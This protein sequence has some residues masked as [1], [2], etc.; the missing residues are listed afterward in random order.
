LI[1]NGTIQIDGGDLYIGGEFSRADLGNLVRNGGNVNIIGTMRNEGQ[2]LT[3]DAST[4]SWNLEEGGRIFGGTI[5][6]MDGAVLTC[7]R[8]TG[9][10]IGVTL[11]IDL[12]ISDT[13]NTTATTNFEIWSGITINRTLSLT[14]ER[15][16]V[17]V[18]GTST[19][20][21][22]GTV[23]M[24]VN[25]FNQSGISSANGGG[26]PPGVS[27]TLT[28]GPDLSIHA[29]RGRIESYSL[30]LQGTFVADALGD[31]I[32]N[33]D[34]NGT[35]S[36]S[37]TIDVDLVALSLGDGTKNFSFVNTG[38]INLHSGSINLG[39]RF[40]LSSLGTLNRS[41]GAIVIKGTFDNSGTELNLNESTGSWRVYGGKIFGGNIRISGGVQLVL[42]PIASELTNVVVNGD[43]N[44]EAPL[45]STNY[46]KL[47]GITVNGN[48]NHA[49]FETDLHITNGLTLN[50]TAV[51]G[52]NVWWEFYGTDSKLDGT[53]TVL[54]PAVNSSA[55]LLT[56][57]NSSLTIGPG[58]SLRGGSGY[59]G[60][61]GW[62]SGVIGG[63][64]ISIINQGRIIADI[65][66]RSLIISPRGSGSLM[67]FGTISA[68][69]GRISILNGDTL[70]S[71][72]PY[73]AMNVSIDGTAILT[74]T[75]EGQMEFKGNLLTNARSR[76]QFNLQGT[77]EFNGVGTAISPQLLEVSSEDRGAIT[78]GFSDNFAI[79]TLKVRGNTNGT[80]AYL[81]LV[82]LSDNSTGGTTEAL[83][84]NTLIVPA[85]ATLDLNGHRVYAKAAL[86]DGNVVNG[87][88]EVIPDSGPIEYAHPTPGKIGTPGELDEWTLY[89]RAGKSVTIEL[90]PGTAG[91]N[92]AITPV[93]QW[94]T[95]QLLN[96]S[97]QIVATSSNSTSGTVIRLTGVQ[98]PTDGTYRLRV[99]ASSGH[100]ASTGNYTISLFDATSTLRSLNLSQVV[101]GNITSP[102]AED[103]WTFT[104]DD[105]TSLR[106]DFRNSSVSGFSFR[107]L[108]PNNSVPI[109]ETSEDSPI[110]TLP[111]PGTY[112]LI[113]QHLTGGTGSY[114]FRLEQTSQRLLPFNGSIEETFTKS[115]Q[116]KLFKVT[117]PT[118]Q[119]LTLQLS[120]P[121]ASDRFEMYASLGSPPS[122]EKYDFR[123][124]A[125]GSSQKITVPNAS[126]GDWYV[127]VYADNLPE[128]RTLSLSASG[129]FTDLTSVV[130]MLSGNSSPV[131]M[132]LTG[133]GFVSGTTV[134][135]VSLDGGTAYSPQIY[136]IDSLTQISAT[137]PASIPSGHYSVRVTTPKGSRE[138]Y[139]SF[140]SISGSGAK[141]ETHLVLPP[142]LGRHAYA[143]LYIEY[144]N[145]GDVP[146][147]APLLSL[148]GSDPSDRPIF[149]LDESRIT[150]KFWSSAL[151]PGAT[152]SL[153][154]V[155]S[156]QQAGIL[157]PGERVRIPVYY[158]GLQQPWDFGDSR[159]ELELRYWT[160][161]DTAPIDW[162][163]KSDSMR[164]S[165]INAEAWSAIFDNLTSEISTTGE[166]V[167]MLN[168]NSIY[169]SRMGKN[170]RD[171]SEL[172]NFEVQQAYGFSVMPTLVSDVDL[173]MPVPGLSLSFSRTYRDA[174]Y[175]RFEYGPFGRG[176]GTEW[177]TVLVAL[178]DR[179]LV[180][181]H[182]PGGSVR[183]YLRDSRNGAYFSLLGD[184][185]TLVYREGGIF[186][187]LSTSGIKTRFL[188]DGRISYVADTND[189]KVTAGYESPGKLISLTHTNGEFITFAYN[190]FGLIST[191]SDSSGRVVH[192]AYDSTGSYLK[193]VTS[194]DG[195]VTL[196]TYQTVGMPQSMHA[197]LSIERGGTTRYFTYDSRGRLDSTYLSGN[198][199]LVDFGYD[200]AGLVTVDED[201]LVP[202]V[203]S[204]FF[205]ENGQIGKTVDELGKLSILEYNPDLRLAK[206]LAPT[207]E[208]QSF[209]W[210]SC[211]SMTSVTNELGQKT[212]FSYEYIDGSFFK[213]MTSLTDAR[214]NTTRY[215][216]DSKG[217][218]LETI[219]PNGSIERLGNYTVEGIPGTFTNRR[220]Q[221]L[222]Y[223]Y[224]SAGQVVQ[225]TFADGSIITFEYDAR[226]NLT[227]TTDGSEV[228][229][230]AYNYAVDGDRLKRVTYPNGRFLD[231]TYDS[232]G[233]RIAMLDQDGYA[234]K[235]EYD[236]AGR[237]YR[238]RDQSD[239]LLITYLYDNAGRL[240][241]IDKGNGTF[242]TYE[243]DAAGQILSL[244]NW[245]DVSTLNSKYDYTYDSRGRRIS[246]S[247]LDG[248]WTY[249][250]DGTGQLI[251]AIFVPGSGSTIP[252]QDLQYIYDSVGNRI[253]TILNDIET[254]YV[255]NNLNQ[256]ISVG[257]VAYSYDADGNLTF[258]GVNTYVYDQQSR[259]IRVTGPEGIIE[260]E[261]DPLGIRTARVVNGVRHELLQDPVGQSETVVEY[262]SDGSDATRYIVGYGVELQSQLSGVMSYFNNDGIG[263]IVGLTSDTQ[264]ETGHAFFLPFG[265]VIEA[266]T[267]VSSS[268]WVNPSGY[269]GITQETNTVVYNR[270]RFQIVGIGRF[271]SADPVRLAG[272]DTNFYRL[273]GND[274][275]RYADPSGNRRIPKLPRNR[276]TLDKLVD[277]A[278]LPE[279]LPGF[280]GDNPCVGLSKIVG[281]GA[282]SQ[283]GTWAGRYVGGGLG[284]FLGPP[285]LLVGAYAGGRLGN[286]LGGI[287]GDRYGEALG[288]LICPYL[289]TP[290][291]AVK[292]LLG[293]LPGSNGGSGTANS[294]DPNDKF[295]PGGFGS[296]NFVQGDDPIPYRI[297]FENY[298]PG[299]KDHDGNPVESSRWAT[300]PAQ[301]VTVS[302]FLS[303]DL[304]WDTF[305]LSEI[306]FGD[307]LLTVPPDS[308]HFQTSYPM[309]YN[310]KTFNVLIEAGIRIATGEVFII[311][312]SIDPNTELP[313]DVLTGFLPP[314][315][316]TG[317]GMGHFSYSVKPRAGLPSGTPIRN[318]ALI[319]F[320]GQL[321]IATDQ[322]D[323][324]DPS[325]GI[326][327]NRQALI[328]IDAAG[329]TSVINSLPATTN[330]PA[331]L[332]NWAG[333]DDTNGSG[334]AGYDIFVSDN[335]GPF[336]PFR[337]ASTATSATFTG[338]VGHSYR[339]YSIAIDNVGHRQ[340]SQT[341]R[342][343]QVVGNNA[344]VLNS[345]GTPA[346]DAIPVNVPNANNPGTLVS[347]II[348]RMSPNGG[349]TDPDPAALR[350]IAVVGLTGTANGTWQFSLNN[351]T[352]WSDMAATGTINAR[353]LAADA[354]TRIR[355]V[356]N[357]GF[358]GTATFAFVAW[359]RTEGA[360]GQLVNAGNR[361]GSR[362]YSSDWDYASI[363]V[364][365]APVLNTAGSPTLDPIT[366]NI[367][368]ANN[369]GTLVSTLISRMSP[370]GSITDVGTGFLKG[371]AINGLTGTAT[372]K[373]Q[374][375][376][377]NGAGWAN[378]LTTGNFDALL[379][380]ADDKTR[381]RYVPNSG[382]TGEA[383][384][385][386]V[387]WDQSS[388][389]NGGTAVVSSRG[390]TTPFSLAYEYASITVNTAPVLNTTGS[391]TLD[392]ITV[393]I[394]NANNVGTLVSTL[395]A[396]M[397]PLGGITDAGAGVLKGIAING[398]TGTTNG[399]WQYS[400]NNGAGWAN[401]SVTGNFDARLLAADDKTR[402][403]YVPNAN[404]TGEAKLAFVA[405]DRSSGINGGT[406]NVASRG[407]TTPYS[408]N[409]DYASV[410]VNTAPVLNTAGSPMLDPI[411]VN[412]PYANNF[413][414][415]V[416]T[417]I[418]RM[419]PMGGITDV[420]TGVLKGIAI[421]GLTGMATGKWQY[422]LNNG[423]GWANILT[424]G[425]FDALLLAADDKT[426]IR[427]VPNSGFTGEAKI[428]F[429]A[430][431]RSTGVNGG[432]ANVASRG[433][434]T[435]YSLNYDYASVTVNT[436]P[437]LNTAGS[438][439]LDPIMVNIPNANNVGTL[440]STL[441]S[442]MSPLGGITDVGTGVLKGIAVVGLTGTTNGI[443]QFSLNN[444]SSWSE[445]A[446]T[447]SINARLLAA[448]SK[449]RIRFV[450]N[451][452]F[453]GTATFAFVAWDLTEGTNGQLINAGNRGG[454]RPYSLDYDYASITVNTAPVLNTAG[455][456]TLDPIPANV[457]NASNPGTLVSTLIS[458]M[459]PLGGI[460]DVGTG[461]L[462]GIAINGLVG[463]GT[464]TWQ[465]SLNNG[466]TW[467]NMAVTGNFNALLLASDP[468][469][470]IRYLPN[471]GFTGEAKIAFVAW[472]R[473][474]GVSGGTANVASRGGTTAFSTAYEYASITVN[475]PQAA[476]SVDF[477]LIDDV[478][479][480]DL[481]LV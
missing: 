32:L 57:D 63:E 351:G 121:V 105:K 300:A 153:I 209:T 322:V 210:C 126:L 103:R 11:D 386:F 346:L 218:L 79:G 323:P 267:S 447:G 8:G 328:T 74:E 156:G 47:D 108:G 299:S 481:L 229:V 169:L 368:N 374:Y 150:E 161:S 436:A 132:T 356:P 396:R 421:N 151:S 197:L 301:F 182:S 114:S 355:F 327:P 413:G 440:V 50:G 403:R 62:N 457:P 188:P 296:E 245:K 381:I 339:F 320:D 13:G 160:V 466:S 357:S 305:R 17:K 65:P 192:Y 25:P 90:N 237:L 158:L 86:I 6:G 443:W 385:A 136:S 303:S 373:W 253:K 144:A 341:I 380:A 395:I 248:D 455:S 445:I 317:R 427:Y 199:E 16:R 122:R 159:V 332:L 304:D 145:T 364:N 135:L 75:P 39:G 337:T 480:S 55:I 470:R 369:V 420:G 279:D 391:P 352:T 297:R 306:G 42:A 220:G 141:L 137:F 350:G 181:I 149:T 330:N 451:P 107:L 76:N 259:L 429:V 448:D 117:V 133:A 426:R 46:V 53:G 454:T 438:P 319:S 397:S 112:T 353:L 285:G 154:F 432:T 456:P 444:G 18:Y 168:E 254:V 382:F 131:N 446:A 258:D 286:Y 85:G 281:A 171:V 288:K 71:G 190:S 295:G 376:L 125:P 189:N 389:I 241:R 200:N 94:A 28:F 272:G 164:P 56:S 143:T 290:I 118:T 36:N 464:G 407:G 392:S 378:I 219:Y 474:T 240:S 22:T 41:G 278:F 1:N 174:V 221:A 222:S 307:V 313:P 463:T 338:I 424:T 476:L 88:V 401:M 33:A 208:S 276:K 45:T 449:T 343:I 467:T 406:A 5:V 120:N 124:V 180:E 113:A 116:S 14:G 260:Y 277:W 402:I 393:N 207:G 365:T 24:N 173:Q 283:A 435:P 3:L 282:L 82:D 433:G 325:Q 217:N 185:S 441:I 431:D 442:R 329:P 148:Q 54:L 263:G 311:F 287:A 478:F 469:T 213:R 298:G 58:I 166:Y 184:G 269:Y 360:N 414:T 344:P 239:I 109:P 408:L 196:Y 333:S 20:Q 308:T 468:N 77:V 216:Y 67:N 167:R 44:F 193:S 358:T 314:E 292:D 186:D 419:S 177:Q 399:T 138:L 96:S 284:F 460:T 23:A 100:V 354:N 472:D 73:S 379:L 437:V 142:V 110:V 84:V 83:Y 59:I 384:I 410:T 91:N 289:P 312:Q 255:T 155:G 178:Q 231:Y 244:K 232:F 165:S 78:S 458:R 452:G 183:T 115:G 37:G 228:T 87:S 434:T 106:F 326:D 334:I 315:D 134:S 270:A 430:W 375:S 64:N 268:I 251:S 415:L 12:Q 423:V 2:T 345:A 176:W 359:D 236:S 309:T 247:T 139:D 280:L 274:P 223:Q 465:Y 163:S 102:Y 262:V 40:T 418:S 411:T 179:A 230:Y 321:A 38:T 412:I 266:G 194:A 336:V 257:G 98:I 172:W 422:S 34:S 60:A 294:S 390:G 26:D 97:N 477:D 101:S 61:I 225:Q 130:P 201:P 69:G 52:S 21:G 127:L 383:K 19:I 15:V 293:G 119:V 170:V 152:T 394:P 233:R 35:L 31:L 361:G 128:T 324:L 439:T 302:D 453:T 264:E 95:I 348:S 215:Q 398:L 147:P 371:I 81:K 425:N 162:A 273:I 261:Y 256:Y 366:V 475:P 250:Y 428:A 318:I 202:G 459:A 416:S 271:A 367:P 49:S 370:L 4:G 204:L 340:T 363:T 291:D 10:L 243:Y 205:N 335:N 9:I 140:E 342:S 265:Q 417:L 104:A 146:M 372:G 349:I 479:R 316:E 388:G 72:A 175:S 252:T 203:V 70:R 246:M 51:L 404:F 99:F 234:T 224:N 409:Y 387:A 462:Q 227:K 43:I 27:A 29:V 275:V 123:F 80:S 235:Y 473:S 187:L 461:V 226:G 238:L 347:T 211:G 30:F 92:P 331:I 66:G 191:A 7:I 68:K 214:G 93:L 129:V 212:V 242:T 377:N 48:I 89:A 310:G 111:Y 400:L 362:P 471:A 450:P 206:V 198:Q 405:W 195:K 249:G 157:N